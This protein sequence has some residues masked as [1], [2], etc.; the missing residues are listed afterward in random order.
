MD[1]TMTFADI[2]KNS[3]V[4]LGNVT[5]TLSVANI[6]FVLLLTFALGL[7][8]FY[9]YKKT[10]QGVLYVSSF[11]ISLVVIAMVTAMIIVAVR[12]NII[13]SLGMVGA[14]SIVRFRTAI[15]DPIDVV[16][17]FWA[18]AVGITNGAFFFKLSIIGTLIIALI[19]IIMSKW[20]FLSMPYLLI[21][22]HHND[23]KN[24]IQQKIQEISP[25]N[26]RSKI[27]S[28]D[29]VELT[30][31]LRIKNNDTDFVNKISR[32]DGVTNA[33]LISYNADKIF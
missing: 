16:F 28:K 19:L 8:I 18:I 32:I 6:V 24:N 17:L 30:I 26:I 23:E 27:V 33:I 15:K 7:V 2:F 14:L 12:S 3:F 25:F 9:I 29:N 13:L 31:E 4:N 21:V 1:Q 20:K 5:T 10:Y 22:N 11:N